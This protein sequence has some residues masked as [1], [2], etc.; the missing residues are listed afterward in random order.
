M[1]SIRL[2]PVLV[3]ILSCIACDRREFEISDK[4][5]LENISLEISDTTGQWLIG[6][7][8]TFTIKCIP[9]YARVQEL[10]LESSDESIFKIIQ[11]VSVNSFDVTAIKEGEAVIYASADNKKVEKS[12]SVYDNSI[13]KEDFEVWNTTVTPSCLIS[14]K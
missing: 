7:T 10:K 5:R 12:F 11:S 2:I 13:K 1:K 14:C 9:D 4:S 6:T 8:R 3:T